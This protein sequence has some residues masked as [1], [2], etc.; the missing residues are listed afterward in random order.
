MRRLVTLFVLCWC[1]TVNA[2]AEPSFDDPR[3]VGRWLGELVLDVLPDVERVSGRSFDGRNPS[4]VVESSDAFQAKLVARYDAAIALAFPSMN[5]ARRAE[6]AQER[7][8]LEAAGTFALY[9]H[10]RD[11][12][13][14]LGDRLRDAVGD[15]AL[16]DVAPIVR[17]MLAHE[18]VHALQARVAGTE[19]P[20]D[21]DASI[22]WRAVREGHAV[23]VEEA[24]LAEIGVQ[25]TGRLGSDT[26]NPDQALR[27]SGQPWGAVFSYGLGAR[28]VQAQLA[29]AP[30]TAA[31]SAVEAPPTRTA[32]LLRA[33]LS[34]PPFTA[35]P[36][37]RPAA[38]FALA[39]DLPAWPGAMSRADG[40]ACV[41]ELQAMF[42]DAVTRCAR[43]L[44]GLETSAERDAG[45]ARGALRVWS[46]DAD[47]R[48]WLD[49]QV[50]LGQTLTAMW[51]AAQ[52]PA[53]ELA[54]LDG[55]PRGARAWSMHFPG[56]ARP[57]TVVWAARDTTSAEVGCL[58][59]CDAKQVRKA[60]KR[61]K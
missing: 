25:L 37:E 41:A 26:T 8:A 2:V 49:R 4:V 15:R 31:W 1:C 29:G 36:A 48:A 35:T 55:L 27:A 38:K 40:Y 7:A 57:L 11:A 13:V 23:L 12:I 58:G 10:E 61:A 5:A 45:V 60:L 50:Q 59:R 56:S 20:A 32:D 42:P 52:G 53:P 44:D 43:V 6:Q 21:H 34:R 3:S 14:V 22:A 54:E 47:A 33:A 39:L 19:S 9:D 30:L 24:L 51:D 28:W 46:T 16:L 17:V 18:L